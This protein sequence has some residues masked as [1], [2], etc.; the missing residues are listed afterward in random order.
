M[1]SCF[2]VV[3]QLYIQ[4]LK[5]KSESES[6]KKSMEYCKNF[7]KSGLTKETYSQIWKTIRPISL[8]EHLLSF[9]SSCET[10]NGNDYEPTQSPSSEMR[11]FLIPE[12]SWMG[13]LGNCR[14]KAKE[15]DQTDPEV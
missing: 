11:N 6:T 1:A 5:E 15:S 12:K 9:M 8:T 2:E 7:L 14:S 13:T 3:D 4:E 10:K